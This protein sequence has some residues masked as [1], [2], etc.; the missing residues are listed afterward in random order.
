[1][2][3]PAWLGWLTLGWLPVRLGQAKPTGGLLVRHVAPLTGPSGGGKIFLGRGGR[4]VPVLLD[5]ECWNPERS[6]P[7]AHIGF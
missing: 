7:F 1:M 4:I 2:G 3:V 5:Y 6:R